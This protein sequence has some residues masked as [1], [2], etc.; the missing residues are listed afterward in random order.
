MSSSELA[1][2]SN[3]FAFRSRLRLATAAA[4]AVSVDDDD[5]DDEGTYSDELL[6]VSVGAMRWSNRSNV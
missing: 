1:V 5:D 4:A 6:T 2:K 3:A